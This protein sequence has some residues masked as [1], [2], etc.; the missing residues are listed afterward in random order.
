MRP[1]SNYSVLKWTLEKKMKK[2]LITLVFLSSVTFVQQSN[3]SIV[4]SGTFFTDT[5]SGLDWLDVTASINRSY[6]DINSQFSVGGD[7]EGWRYATG[8]QL[9]TL[10]ENH[11]G[12]SI[13]DPIPSSI[14]YPNGTLAE[15]VSYFGSTFEHSIAKFT[16]GILDDNAIPSGSIKFTG[17]LLTGKE[18]F[19]LDAYKPH[20]GS[21]S[22]SSLSG[23]E[24]GSFLIRGDEIPQVPVPAAIWLFSSG[25]VGLIGMNRKSSR[26]AIISA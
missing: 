5:T 2:K 13:I 11:T 17:D 15:L 12:A 8:T 18:S 22:T 6:N 4:D 9:N 7:F 1:E 26:I 23:N 10:I 25:L 14:T 3:A 24:L 20:I 19:I 16:T 21:I